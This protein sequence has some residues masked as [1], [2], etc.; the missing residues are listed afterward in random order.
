MRINSAIV[1]SIAAP[2][3][4]AERLRQHGV[5]ND[6]VVGI[7]LPRSAEL[8]LTVLA[9]LKCGAA[10]LP[11]DPS[12]PAERLRHMVESAKACL[13]LSHSSLA[14]CMPQDLAPVI[15]LDRDWPHPRHLD[16]S[17][18]AAQPHGLAYVMYTSGSTGRPKGVAM[19][20][21][22]L[23]NLVVWQIEHSDCG[24]GTR[25][26]QFSSISFDVSFQEIFATWCA[27]G[28]LVTIGEDERR[29][30]R[31]LLNVIEER[32]LHRLFLPFVALQQLAEAAAPRGLDC[33]RLREVITAGEQLRITPAIT[34]LFSRLG[35]CRLVNQYGP[36]EA[37]VV[38][39]FEL[40]GPTQSWP[41]LP[42]IGRPI[43]NVRL[44]ILDERM[45]PVPPGVTGELYIGGR[46]LAQGYFN[47]PQRTT[48]RFVPDPFN[49]G[50]RLY[51][52]G[53][54]CRL[55][56]DGNIEFL[57]RGDKQVKIRGYRVELGEI[58]AELSAHPTVRQAA[59]TAPE[60]SGGNRRIVAHIVTD[61]GQQADESALRQHLRHRLPEFMIPSLFVTLDHMPLGATGKIDRS[62]LP[63][64]EPSASP[65]RPA[66][67]RPRND[68][69]RHLAEIWQEVLGRSKVGVTENFFD[70]GGHS[71]LAVRLFARVEREFGRVLPLA[72]LFK[73]PTIEQLAPLLGAAPIAE[74][75][76]DELGR[77]I[78]LQSKGGR[79]PLFCLP[80][81]GGHVFSFRRFAQLLGED[82]PVYGV[83]LEGVQAVRAMPDTME[84]IAAA[85]LPSIRRIQPEGPYYLGG[86]SA[87]GSVAYEIA[88]QLER[89]G[90]R[91]ALLAMWDAYAPGPLIRRPLVQ[92]LIVHAH[93]FGALDYR[94]KGSIPAGTGRRAGAPAEGS[95]SAAALPPG[96]LGRRRGH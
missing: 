78:P 38:S 80:G 8:P 60:D 24:P 54:L 86:Y 83:Q 2:D 16:Q 71:L 4:L 93:R 47:D 87:G 96:R 10:Y 66:S 94:G 92:R 84:R 29:D 43:A 22:A 26:L 68:T 19:P 73:Y 79:P 23:A 88:Q 32:E 64:P 6:S 69:E 89:Q 82:Q 27:G 58:E 52:T 42:P 20:H 17:P 12:Y 55:R 90:Q 36:T 35:Q 45:R 33:V 95:P 59:V 51:R 15:C 76:P 56:G 74:P 48:E 41:P 5:R 44:F 1:R 53:D 91:V 75:Q 25:T 37:H 9:V 39:E 49:E 14:S 21:V 50:W 63:P 30:P 3:A 65:S 70:L 28:T 72:H 57:G 85:L 7:C 13:L 11:L 61:H 81:S 67:V 31:A 34:N 46:C 40:Q 18:P 62:V 77:I